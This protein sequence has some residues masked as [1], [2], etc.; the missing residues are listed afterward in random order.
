MANKSKE[1]ASV[2]ARVHK[3]TLAT[4]D[5]MAEQRAKAHPGQTHNRTT[6][7][8]ELLSI[9]LKAAENP[10][11]LEVGLI[12]LK[13]IDKLSDPQWVADMKKR[14]EEIA[15]VDMV[16][17]LPPE[18]LDV[19]AAVVFDE[20]RIKAGKVPFSQLDPSERRKILLK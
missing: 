14:L 16:A 18:K 12:V 20:L 19:L 2:T 1:S 6:V 7:I 13:H 3:D 15:V 8:N 9:G 10:R 5:A 11:A 17:T 4:I